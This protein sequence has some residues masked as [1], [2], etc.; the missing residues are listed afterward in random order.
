MRAAI[1]EQPGAH[2]H[3]FA[4]TLQDWFDMRNSLTVA[5]AIVLGAQTRTESRGAHQRE[6]HPVT[7]PD[8]AHNLMT[9]LA[10]GELTAAPAAL[11]NA[12]HDPVPLEA[13]Q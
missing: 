9:R 6:D 2:D 5:E 11:I 10:D 4:M 13:A 12:T 1:G 7:D 8:Q 3:R